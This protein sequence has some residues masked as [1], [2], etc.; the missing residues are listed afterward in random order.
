M[1]HLS[2]AWG[3]DSLYTCTIQ[4]ATLIAAFEGPNSSDISRRLGTRLS[5]RCSGR[6]SPPWDSARMA[7][8]PGSN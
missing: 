3:T 4:W 5:L 1:M 2:E 7:Y 6:K 8:E